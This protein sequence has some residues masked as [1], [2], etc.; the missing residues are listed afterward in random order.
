M[1]VGPAGYGRM[2]SRPPGVG[3]SFR[4]GGGLVLPLRRGRDEAEPAAA[5]EL[6]G[7]A[8]R[9][10]HLHPL[11]APPAQRGVGAARGGED[12]KKLFRN[13]RFDVFSLPVAGRI[14]RPETLHWETYAIS[15][16]PKGVRRHGLEWQRKVVSS[17][18]LY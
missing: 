14:F 5:S 17:C 6:R 3:R 16:C 9:R 13:F 8:A 2:T 10:R 1:F 12:K 11:R 15:F 18:F 4:R 7:S